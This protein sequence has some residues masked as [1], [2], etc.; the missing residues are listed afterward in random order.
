MREL[1]ATVII[2]V[3]AALAVSSGCSKKHGSNPAAEA[4]PAYIVIVAADHVLGSGLHLLLNGNPNDDLFISKNQ[5]YRFKTLLVSGEPYDITVVQQPTGPSQTCTLTKGTG[6]VSGGNITAVIT[7]TTNKYTVGGTV[8]GLNGQ[9]ILHNDVPKKPYDPLTVDANG[10]FT[11]GK[12]V[13]DGSNYSISVF[14][15]PSVQTCTVSHA[16]G[17]LNGANADTAALNCVD[18]VP[19]VSVKSASVVEGD[20]ATST[21]AFTVNLSLLARQD[22]TVDY[23][24][25]DGTATLADND[26][27][28]TSGTL[29]IFAGTNSST[30]NVPVVGDT[31]P[32]GNESLTLTLSNPL[33]LTSPTPTSLSFNGDD[34]ATG[35]IYNDDGGALNDTGITGCTNA[36]TNNLTCGTTGDGTGIGAGGGT[37]TYPVQDAEIGRDVTV[38][39]DTDGHAGFSFEKYNNA[40]LALADQSLA[41]DPSGSEA[42][43]TQWSCVKDQTTGLWW[44]A[45][46]TNGGLHDQN[47]TY[48]WYDTDST[49]NGGYPGTPGGGVCDTN[50]LTAC[51]TEKLVTA[52]NS[53]GLCGYNDW[54]LP[55]VEELSSLIDSS[56]SLGPTIDTAWFPNTVSAIYW[57][58]SPYASYGY[59]AWGVDFSTGAIIGNQ[60]K[61]KLYGNY[62]RLV[63]GGP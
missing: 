13:A 39:D 4:P 58:A 27:T 14:R 33:L 30:I 42:A 62:V 31:L 24:T 21:L 10:L 22:V 36:D 17:I 5:T 54:R 43:N 61:E 18:N 51:D 35:T 52:V 47:G 25:S 48:S 2:A 23:A 59:Y 53:G 37:T 1:K 19:T 20:T 38:N 45:K 50:T 44:E 16:S 6:V 60:L 41:W 57:T 15:Q 26:Y 29:T 49:T 12:E 63:R 7:C 3:L 11:F 8:T 32:E 56:V 55:T 34:F 46:T 28:A 9:V 40:G